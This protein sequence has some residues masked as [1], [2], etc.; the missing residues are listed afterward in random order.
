M[1]Q[2]Y[3]D[4]DFEIIDY[5]LYREPKTGLLLRGPAPAIGADSRFIACVGAAQ[6][7]GCY[8]E[9]PYP[10]MLSEATA[11]PVLNFG[12]AGAGPKWF[13]SKPAVISRI[14]EASLV[15]LQV[16]SGRSESNSLF[17]SRGGE[18]LVRRADGV[19]KGAEPMYADL[20]RT[21]EPERVEQLIE[22]TRL[23]WVKNFSDL[24]QKITPPTIL[25]WFAKRAI[26]YS[27]GYENPRALFGG[28]PQLVDQDW[29]DPLRALPCAFV[30]C[31][32]SRGCPQPLVSRFTGQ[33]CSIS[34]RAYLGGKAKVWNDY[35]PSPE[36]HSD[37]AARLLPVCRSFLDPH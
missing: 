16:M 24:M 5:Q 23:N 6:T 31:V 1:S 29:V 12:I 7:F 11:T 35:Y 19:K 14:N 15:I 4:R 25:F 10:A 37:A 2:G 18:M 26:R 30:E 28:F 33:R 13:L 34:M 27:R 8:T 22:E 21:C 36:M 9:D 17:E 3:Q 20:L 32:S